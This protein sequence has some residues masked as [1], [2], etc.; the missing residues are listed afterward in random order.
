MAYVEYEL[1]VQLERLKGRCHLRGLALDGRVRLEQCAV[2]HL[3]TY[4][5]RPNTFLHRPLTAR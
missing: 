3:A 5:R 1:K 2:T 4:Y